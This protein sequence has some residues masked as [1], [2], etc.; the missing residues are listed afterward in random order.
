MM[1]QIS[2]FNYKFSLFFIVLYIDYNVIEIQLYNAYTQTYVYI[3]QTRVDGFFGFYVK[4]KK[5]GFY[6]VLSVFMVFTVFTI[7]TSTNYNFFI[8]TN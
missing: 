5:P 6:R 7:Q 4:T 1:K 2:F 8:T 3:I